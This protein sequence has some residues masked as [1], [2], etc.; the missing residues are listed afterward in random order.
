MRLH[1]IRIH[2]LGPFR[3]VDLNLSDIPSDNKIVAIS[4]ENGAGKSTLLEL[5]TGG[6]LFRE[7]RTRGT[8]ASL[9]TARD[10]SL[11]V[12][13]E[14]DQHWSVKHLVDNVSGKGGS[15]ASDAFGAMVTKS[16]KVRDFDTFASE[17]LPSPEVLY[18]SMV[19]CQQ[20]PGFLDQK[21]G[22][23]KATL[24][25][26][27][28]VE[29]LEDLAKRARDFAR[30]WLSK[31]ETLR[32]RIRDEEERA[33]VDAER[34]RLDSVERDVARATARR[35]E[36][37][38]S[39]DVAKELARD[40]TLAKQRYQEQV[41]A[42][43]IMVSRRNELQIDLAGV[44]HRVANNLNVLAQADQI[45]AAVREREEAPIGD[46]DR[47]ALEWKTKADSALLQVASTRRELQAL[48]GQIADLEARRDGLR[49][50]LEKESEIQAASAELPTRRNGIEQM[51]AQVMRIEAELTKLRNQRL[52][53]AEQR[54]GSLRGGLDQIRRDSGAESATVNALGWIAAE[55][56]REDTCSEQASSDHPKK[57][58]AFEEELES[59]KTILRRAEENLRACESLV[60]MAGR[61][62]E[63]RIALAK[64]DE[65]LRL[66]SIRDVQLEASVEVILEEA[67]TYHTKSKEEQAKSRSLRE[68]LESLVPLLKLEKPLETAEARLSELEPQA[69]RLGAELEELLARLA[70]TPEPV[71][72]SA[73]PEVAALEVALKAAQSN[74]AMAVAAVGASEQRLAAG[75]EAAAKVETM[76]VE[77][78]IVEHEHADWARL[79]ADL[80]RDGLQAALI[81][82]A[83]PE[84]TAVTNDLLHQCVSTRWTV[85]IET[86]RASADGKK[87]LEGLEVRVLDSRAGR[88]T[89]AETLSGGERA[90]VGE[91]LSLA[92]T[93]LACRRAGL[94]APTIV[95]DETSAALDER[96]AGAYVSM[97]RRAASQIGASR[98]LVVSHDPRVSEAC[99]ARIEVGGGTARV[100]T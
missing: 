64:T 36:A 26:L 17:K 84:L 23:R 28:G 42:R 13:F 50:A 6:A 91:A 72:P 32:A 1:S 75:R 89:T 57:L 86:Q 24:L 77:L 81:D 73:A 52:V 9:A 61:L 40:S 88:D 98:V 99:D 35:D 31:A 4:G 94:E 49:K 5:W 62:E 7:C 85:S 60:T 59:T 14:N 11:E 47:A 29:R 58:R 65:Q 70:A 68:R 78:A 100:A 87:T 20:S 69:Q 83:G 45:R 34:L 18:S 55:T 8:L 16:G 12:S 76:R 44:Q 27:L 66:C 71:S 22:D 3:D 43:E 2:N 92:L 10:A 80:G 51:R 21:P 33:D 38:Q 30:S 37:Q 48:V 15:V 56:L 97:L 25:R 46:H 96:N 53:G 67:D 41:E 74:H 79:R 39:L 54:I 95:R 93:T 63:D 90:L 82:S 19:A